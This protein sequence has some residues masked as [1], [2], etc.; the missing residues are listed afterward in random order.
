[1]KTIIIDLGDPAHEDEVVERLVSDLR[2][3]G[4][5]IA[6][7]SYYN[8]AVAMIS[9]ISNDIE[10][11]PVEPPVETEPSP[12]P[13]EVTMDLPIPSMAA[14][15]EI[16]DELPPAP[17]LSADPFNNECVIMSLS[18]SCAV[19]SSFV[20]EQEISLLKATNVSRIGEF[21][22]FEYC[23]LTF[24]YPVADLS[25]GTV[26]NV[27]PMT[28]ETSI[29]VALQFCGSPTIYPV[30][31]C[32]CEKGP[33]DHCSVVFGKDLEELINTKDSG[34]SIELPTQ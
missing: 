14:V 34:D 21:V 30:L 23:G 10:S 16:P 7:T 12:T 33:D 17:S 2:G 1:M 27:S 24:K 20:P 22:S 9:S 15:P 13:A 26:C 6:Y 8:N 31:L 3:A 18:T 11:M 4:F 28:T 25:Q 5:N 19:P 29:K 32:V